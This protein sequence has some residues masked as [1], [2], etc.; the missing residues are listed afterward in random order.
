MAAY[1][2]LIPTTERVK[3]G[4]KFPQNCANRQTE[5]VSPEPCVVRARRELRHRVRDKEKVERTQTPNNKSKRNSEHDMNIEYV[6]K[7]AKREDFTQPVAAQLLGVWFTDMTPPKVT[8]TKENDVKLKA[9]WNQM[10]YEM[11]QR[12]GRWEILMQPTPAVLTF[13]DEVKN[14]VHWRDPQYGVFVYCRQRTQNVKPPAD[15][16]P[17][18]KPPADPSPL[19]KPPAEPSPLVKPPAEPSPLVKP[20]AEPSPLVKPPAEPS[21]LP[22]NVLSHYS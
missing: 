19:V 11:I 15:P 12:H 9:T 10:T 3:F 7:I 1:I 22:N 2:D 6:E 14:E 13:Y 5:F 4:L 17:L 18:V 20:P 21:P 16:S 8:I